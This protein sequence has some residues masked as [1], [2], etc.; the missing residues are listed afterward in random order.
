MPP[1]L[2]T[3]A[4]PMRVRTHNGGVDQASNLWSTSRSPLQILIIVLLAVAIRWIS[5][6]SST[7]SSSGWPPR[8]AGTPR[9]DPARRTQE[10]SE[11]LMSQRR[12]QR[13]EAIGALLRSVIT[14]TVLIIALLL[15][16]PIL[17]V[18]VAPL[19]ASAGV[20]GGAGLGAQSLVKDHRPGSSWS[21]EGPVRRRRSR[22][23]RRGVGVVRTSPLRDHP[24]P[25]RR[26]LVRAQRRDPACGQPVAGAGY[27]PQSTSPWLTTEPSTRCASASTPWPRTCT[28]TRSTTTCSWA[29]PRMP[30]GVGER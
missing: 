24:V 11:V 26:G 17:G 2:P 16:L 29:S 22:G 7:A 8:A 6:R 5:S 18:D 30:G 12:Q 14:A 3:S 10:L 4:Q 9:R 19:L 25:V 28:A 1:I 15:I 23:P 13:A 21:F 20:L 27:W